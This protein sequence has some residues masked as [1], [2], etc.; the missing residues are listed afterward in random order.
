MK[1][2]T[3]HT[4]PLPPAARQ[5]IADL[6]RKL[7]K[8]QRDLA[9]KV[10]QALGF[11]PDWKPAA[12]LGETTT[13]ITVW[14]QY[15]LNAVY[16]RVGGTVTTRAVERSTSDELLWWTATE[17]LLTVDLP[18][19][20]QVQIVTDWEEPTGGRELPVMQSIA[21]TDLIAA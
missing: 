16:E 10:G 14:S 12:H 21:E 3:R 7:A 1:T 4:A 6:E 5:A 17:I 2:Q 11:H 18:G 9:T 19:I 20:A 13:Y 15:E 8:P